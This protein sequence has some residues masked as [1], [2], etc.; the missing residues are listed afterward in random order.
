[1]RGTR[2]ASCAIVASIAWIGPC[3][4]SAGIIAADD[5]SY[6]DGTLLG[7]NGGFGWLSPWTGNGV[8]VVSGR[9]ETN[10]V[11]NP[12]KYGFRVFDNPGSTGDLFV[13]FGFNTANFADSDY[14]GCQLSVG[15]NN[16]ILLFGKGV[17]GTTFGVGNS[18]LVSTG[19]TVQPNTDY[20]LIG[21][22]HVVPGP[23]PDQLMLWVNPDGADFFNTVT[24]A[25]SADAVSLEL[26]AFHA[27]NFNMFSGIAGTRF[28]DLVISND[29]SGVG[30]NVPAPASA[31]AVV[32]AGFLAGRR[33]RDRG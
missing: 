21:A 27:S 14:F 29:A 4:A 24:G 13:R 31:G 17:G 2:C 22:Y 10:V 9:A 33:R 1:M 23:D 25:T 6:P 12:P 20:V 7:L 18:G 3:T 30:L 19:I 11:G 32:W 28:D 8:D 16:N 15:V 5:F 26:V